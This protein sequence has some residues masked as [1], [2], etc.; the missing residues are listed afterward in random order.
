MLVTAIFVCVCVHAQ[1]CT[2]HI[3]GAH[4][5]T[6]CMHGT[7]MYE[8]HTTCTNMQEARAYLGVE[9]VGYTRDCCLVAHQCGLGVLDRS[10]LIHIQ[11]P[12]I[13]NTTTCSLIAMTSLE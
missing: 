10:Q 3:L 9:L 6:L 11:L 12:W 2:R 13:T 7:N 4:T 5:G 1:I 8:A